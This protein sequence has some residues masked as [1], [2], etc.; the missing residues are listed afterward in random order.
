[1]R[2][3]LHRALPAAHPAAGTVFG[4]GDELEGRLCLETIQSSDRKRISVKD[5]ACTNVL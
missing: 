2:V 1:M 5:G 3:S 4:R